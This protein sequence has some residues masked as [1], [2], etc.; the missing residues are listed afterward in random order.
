FTDTGI[1]AR[2]PDYYFSLTRTSRDAS[3]RAFVAS[4]EHFISAAQKG[5]AAIR[6][7]GLTFLNF[8]L[9]L[10]LMDNARNI[11]LQLQ[12]AIFDH[13]SKTNGTFSLSRRCWSSLVLKHTRIHFDF[14][15]NKNAPFKK[16][17]ADY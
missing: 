9:M 11:L 16:I 8:K 6:A 12:Y 3:L 1:L 7:E 10:A 15:L 2:G 17:A 4:S 14:L 5:T 13:E